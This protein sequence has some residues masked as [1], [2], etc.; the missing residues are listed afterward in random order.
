MTEHNHTA[1]QQ[2]IILIVQDASAKGEIGRITL[3]EFY[4]VPE[5][6]SE[7]FSVRADLA[8]QMAELTHTVLRVLVQEGFTPVQDTFD[9]QITVSRA[10]MTAHTG[11]I[12]I[13]VPVREQVAAPAAAP[14]VP[15]TSAV[16]HDVSDDLFN[17]NDL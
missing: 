7:G 13:L 4:A 14:E 15:P 1:S 9:L 17:L 12:H 8:N 2:A 11:D 3:D 10:L 6:E 16:S 5:G